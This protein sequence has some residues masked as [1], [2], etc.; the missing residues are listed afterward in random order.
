[1]EYIKQQLSLLY[2][3]CD[4]W[5]VEQVETELGQLLRLGFPTNCGLWN[6]THWYY[7]RLLFTLILYVRDVKMKGEYVVSYAMIYT[8]YEYH[9]HL[10]LNAVEWLV[11]PETESETP[12]YGCWKDMKKL[13]DYVYVKTQNTR[14]PLIFQC[15]SVLNTG[16]RNNV[17]NVAKWIPREKSKHGWLFEL[18][19][20]HWSNLLDSSM[21]L[22]LPFSLEKPDYQVEKWKIIHRAQRVYRKH[23]SAK[24]RELKT[25]EIY[26]CNDRQC[27]AP[28]NVN[29]GT[30]HK[31]VGSLTNS[32]DN[33]TL[34]H[35]KKA[36]EIYSWVS[37]YY[38]QQTHLYH[39]TLLG[40]NIYYSK[41]YQG[42][43]GQ[44]RHMNV[45]SNMATKL[46][47][48]DTKF[49][50]TLFRNILEMDIEQTEL[51]RYCDVKNRIDLLNREW[52]HICGKCDV[53]HNVLPILDMS[54]TMF[55]DNRDHW[56]NA[57][58]LACLIASKTTLGGRILVMDHIPTWVKVEDSK[59]WCV[60]M[61]SKINKV[62]GKTRK[63]VESVMTIL[64][65]SL[66]Q[67]KMTHD[68]IEQLVF[69]FLSDMKF[70]LG[71]ETLHST[72]HKCYNDYFESRNEPV[73]PLPYIVYWNVGGA[74][75]LP[76]DIHQ[77]RVSIVGGNTT[78]LLSVLEKTQHKQQRQMN[79]FQHMCNTLT[80][81]RYANVFG[82]VKTV[83]VNTL[84]VEQ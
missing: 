2:Y 19:A 21:Y 51:K 59:Q 17:S 13:A 77:S 47:L 50:D 35:K 81:A 49:G 48:E 64:A 41:P 61:M 7:F 34:D 53:L 46:E 23:V 70:E 84:T 11:Y 60:K 27:I 39:T 6:E 69:V 29:L 26:L 75:V 44:N 58:G 55:E 1:M 71:E 40:Y 15:I 32:F 68:Q 74:T 3:I 62:N 12:K 30:L 79:P 4:R 38:N 45:Y 25:T 65:E 36:F 9:P 73:P 43:M 8:L 20:L 5:S 76:C 24:N 28:E 80:D 67:S 52:S 54:L 31:N 22:K 56:N 83:T 37:K 63:S 42:G 10:A 14:H 72:I 18:L 78:A 33:K 66:L 82:S 16:L 57:L